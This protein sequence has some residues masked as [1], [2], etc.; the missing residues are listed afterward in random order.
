[1]IMASRKGFAPAY[2][3][4]EK[5]LITSATTRAD[6]VRIAAQIGRSYRSVC[7]KAVKLGRSFDRAI[8]WNALLLRVAE[9]KERDVSKDDMARDLG[10]SLTT[11]YRALRRLNLSKPR[12]VGALVSRF[13]LLMS[14]AV[15]MQISTRIAAASE[16]KVRTRGKQITDDVARLGFHA[17]S[18]STPQSTLADLSGECVKLYLKSWVNIHRPIKINTREGLWGAKPSNGGAGTWT[19]SYHYLGRQKYVGIYP[20]EREAHEAAVAHRD[21]N[22]CR[23]NA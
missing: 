22:Q 7:D 13:N 9:L 17:P 10:V 1:M 21:A 4:D 23:E 16:Y 5:R 8:D 6:L 2:T 18:E 20:T 14:A 15:D 3:D 11:I 12:P 19:A